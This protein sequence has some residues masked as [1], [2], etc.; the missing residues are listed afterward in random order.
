MLELVRKALQNPEDIPG[1]LYQRIFDWSYGFLYNQVKDLPAQR[2]LIHDFIRNEEFVI[3]VLDACRY[4]YFS[5]IYGS[6]VVG[7]LEAGWAT[8]GWTGDYVE[9]TWTEQYDLT[10]LGAATHVSDH[11]FQFRGRDYRPS[12]HIDRIVQLWNTDWNPVYGTVPPEKVTAAALAQAARDGP[13]RMVVHYMQPHSPYIGE[14]KILPWGIDKRYHTTDFD[15]LA[16][17]AARKAE[18]SDKDLELAVEELDPAKINFDTVVEYD[19]G[20]RQFQQWEEARP[21]DSIIDRIQSGEITDAELRQAYRDNL[22]LVCSEVERLIS[23]LDCSVV[24]T[25]DHGEFLGESGRYFHPKTRHP[26]VR[27]IPWLTVAEECVGTK[28]IEEEYCNLDLQEMVETDTVD[29]E[30]FTD[31]LRALGYLSDG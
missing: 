17:D 4:D 23:R 21:T 11:S 12:E 5:E 16:R 6:Y 2:A 28:S 30:T 31:R 10:Y 8:A 26:L 14:T 29:D 19:L 22:H 20:P 18:A 13:T 9:K 24:V 25:S 1:H 15:Q 3:V 27:E 7:E